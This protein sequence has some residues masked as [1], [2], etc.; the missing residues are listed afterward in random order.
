MVRVLPLTG[1]HDRLDFDCGSQELNN[2]LRRI[3]RHYQDK[4]LSRTF[5][6]IR[7]TEPI[8]ICGYYALTLTEIEGHHL[9]VLWRQK[10]LRRIPGIRMG[11]LAIAQADQG[12]GLGKLLLVNAL[13]RIRRIHQEAGGI[14]VC[15]CH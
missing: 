2:W 9:P 14:A 10:L 6:A 3:A 8:R 4:G 5:V 1:D 12:R 15:R 13:T 7:E 11:R